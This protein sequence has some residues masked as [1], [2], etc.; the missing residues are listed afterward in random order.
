VTLSDTLKKS[1]ASQDHANHLPNGRSAFQRNG[2]VSG[3]HIPGQELGPLD[4][5]D[6]AQYLEQ[7]ST[8]M[9]TSFATWD[10]ITDEVRRH[11]GAEVNVVERRR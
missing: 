3:W 9:V 2:A 1:I 6:G 7:G 8:V 11:G 5:C 4:P 10:E